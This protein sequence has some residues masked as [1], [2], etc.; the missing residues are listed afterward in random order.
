MTFWN[1]VSLGDNHGTL[2]IPK[3]DKPYQAVNPATVVHFRK[4]LSN[5]LVDSLIDPYSNHV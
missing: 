5:R 1:C 2:L 4:R 3:C